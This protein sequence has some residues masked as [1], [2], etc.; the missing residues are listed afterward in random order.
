MKS[1]SLNQRNSQNPSLYWRRLGHLWHI[2]LAFGREKV[3]VIPGC[4]WP[5][6]C[7]RKGHGDAGLYSHTC[8]G[9]QPESLSDPARQVV[10]LLLLDSN[11]R[12]GPPRRALAMRV[13]SVGLVTAM[14][15]VSADLWPAFPCFHSCLLI[16][17]PRI[18]QSYDYIILMRLHGSTCF[19]V[20]LERCQCQ[21]STEEQVGVKLGTV[22]LAV[23]RLLKDSTH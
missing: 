17:Q 2:G 22:P 8:R 5:H 12:P 9:F 23:M 20:R 10:L 3:K 6:L 4:E 14:L 16:A 18:C 21:D 1:V 11:T 15:L 7:D 19:A 13:F